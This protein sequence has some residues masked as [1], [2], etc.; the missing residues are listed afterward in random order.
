MPC[1]CDHLEAMP[2]E[3]MVSKVKCLLE[4]LDGKSIDKSDWDGY[5]PEVYCKNIGK[6]EADK[7]VAE[8]CS[9]LQKIDVT[10]YSLELQMWWRDHKKADLERVEKELAEIQNEE[11]R[12]KALKK[13]TVYERKLLGL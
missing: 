5:H 3:V 7:L 11:D 10:K 4:E 8:L 1:N 9:K 2:F 13:L 12:Q 6:I